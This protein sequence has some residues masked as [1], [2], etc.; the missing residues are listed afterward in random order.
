MSYFA[1]RAIHFWIEKKLKTDSMD[2]MSGS[3]F[4]KLIEACDKRVL[5]VSYE[6]KFAPQT[7]YNFMN[8]EPVTRRT[9]D[10]LI[11]YA[12]RLARSSKE[13]KTAVS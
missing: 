10:A 2:C 3:D 1:S 8:G 13:A 4:K 6:T 7:I 11:A 12:K 9:R 5:D